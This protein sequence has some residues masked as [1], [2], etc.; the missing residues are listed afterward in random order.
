MLERLGDST[1]YKFLFTRDGVDRFGS[2]QFEELRSRLRTSRAYLSA[3]E[4][5][6]VALDDFQIF[7]WPPTLS[8]AAVEAAIS[9]LSRALDIR[10]LQAA[11]TAAAPLAELVENLRK[12]ETEIGNLAALS[13]DVAREA[14]LTTEPLRLSGVIA[15]LPRHLPIEILRRRPFQDAIAALAPGEIE[16]ARPFP[17]GGDEVELNDLNNHLHYWVEPLRERASRA[18][19]ADLTSLTSRA[20][21]AWNF[22]LAA[23][24]AFFA[25]GIPRL[26]EERP[27][28]DDLVLT[29]A[30][31]LPSRVL[32]YNLSKDDLS[33]GDAF[34][35]TELALA[36]VASHWLQPDR[37][38]S[39]ELAPAWAALAGLRR[40]GFSRNR[41]ENSRQK[42]ARARAKAK[43]RR[44]DERTGRTRFYPTGTRVYPTGTRVREPWLLRR[45]P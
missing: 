23:I 21:R 7:G 16:P 15:T 40:L 28:F 37:S 35:W 24:D 39:A 3:L 11:R 18:S 8:A 26:G 33:K 12:F 22:W 34:G 27:Q 36:A 2:Q 31:R 14:R 10:D 20:E 9:Q 29:A 1:S 5:V 38:E 32:R 4:T 6:G 41:L 30:G 17:V 43:G 42:V 45:P 19:H 25:V 44:V 13:A